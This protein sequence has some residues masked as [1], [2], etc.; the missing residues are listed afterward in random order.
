MD[1]T[2]REDKIFAV[3]AK[4]TELLERIVAMYESQNRKHEDFLNIVQSAIKST[5]SAIR[6]TDGIATIV[7][8]HGKRIEKLSGDINILAKNFVNIMNGDIK[9]L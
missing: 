4:Q 6:S 8:E 2:D 7:A 1:K 9:W 5:D 3:L